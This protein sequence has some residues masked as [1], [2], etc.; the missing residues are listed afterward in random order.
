MARA[1]GR[2]SRKD[3]GIKEKR[4]GQERVTLDKLLDSIQ[5]IVQ[6]YA[7]SP[8]DTYKKL[9]LF[10]RSW[11]YRRYERPLKDPILLSYTTEE[12]LYEFYDFIERKKAAEK[13]SEED[14]D[15]IEEERRQEA[16]DWAEQEEQKELN[17]LNSG[18]IKPE[19]EQEVKPNITDADRAWMEQKLE[20][21]KELY[22]EDF[23]QDIEEDFE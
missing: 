8:I 15:R 7:N 9:D 13:L 17:E 18:K 5:A 3:Q 11:W 20:E 12:L 22:G 10:L 4:R 16:F 19:P 21:A 1:T 23:G 2:K 6:Y 14:D